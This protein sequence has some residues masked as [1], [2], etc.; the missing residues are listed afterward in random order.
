MMDYLQVLQKLRSTKVLYALRR[1][2]AMH[3]LA[4][5]LDFPLAMQVT[6]IDFPIYASTMRNISF[7][8]SRARLFEVDERR[9]FVA[10]LETLDVRSL[11]D[12]GANIG[13]Y[14]FTALS[15]RPSCRIVLV[16][17]DHYNRLL[18]RKTIGRNRLSGVFLVEK[19]V[20]D[21][22]GAI[23]FLPDMITGSTGSIFRSIDGETFAE[24]HYKARVRAVEVESTTLDAM[25][26]ELGPPDFVKI[27]VEGAE[28]AV[29]SGGSRTIA[30][31]RPVLMF[32]A[33]DAD[34][35][36]SAYLDAIDRLLLANGYSL[37]DLAT[38]LPIGRPAFN[39]LALP[40]EK[41]AA[42]QASAYPKID[43]SFRL[44]E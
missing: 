1:F 42:V 29:L 39:S 43:S 18:L 33:R 10:M 12:V 26:D 21:T 41:A 17:P 31:A 27:D 28:L 36:D 23:Q 15:L 13:I 34:H 19:A 8:L 11:W 16:E 30:E 38:L 3:R 2:P 14:G 25:L 5:A 40:C 7:L 22:I 44:D 35:Q 37:F 20:S 6:G 24:H 9:H 32:E 4:A